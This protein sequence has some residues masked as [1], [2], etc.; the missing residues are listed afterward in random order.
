MNELSAGRIILFILGLIS[1]TVPV[2]SAII[3]YFPLWMN[4]GTGSVISGFTL[5]LLMGAMLPLWKSVKRILRSPSAY[6]MWFIAFMIFFMLAKIADEMTVICFVGF[7]SNLIGAV[8]FRA[9]KI[10][11]PR[12][13]NENE[14]R[15]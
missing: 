11:L 10:R 8:F 13:D 6:V 2:T 1:C 9:S 3:L 5:L 7:V 15:I 4:E 12:R 14:G